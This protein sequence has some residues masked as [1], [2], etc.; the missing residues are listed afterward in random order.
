[1]AIQNPTTNYGW[2]L[3]TV[4]GSAD[5]WGTILNTLLGDDATGIDAIVKA[6]SDVANA[7]LPKAGGAMTGALLLDTIGE[8]TAGSGVTID[9]LLIK[10]GAI[11]ASGVPSLD[12]AK[13]TSGTFNAARIPSLDAAKITTG[14]FDAARI[15]DLSGTYATVASLGAYLADT[16]GGADWDV[17]TPEARFISGSTNGPE[18]AVTYIGINLPHASADYGVQ[19][20]GRD[21]D[22]YARSKESG[23]WSAWVAFSMAGHTHAASAISAGTFGAGT[24]VFPSVLQVVSNLIV[25]GLGQWGSF[26]RAQIGAA[27]VT[28]NGNEL[29][30]KTGSG[31]SG[32]MER[33]RVF[34][35]GNVGI[36]YATDQGYKLAVN[37]TGLFSGAVTASSF[38]KSA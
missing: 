21:G 16:V 18:A 33:A 31:T 28:D 7:A 3:P 20:A 32:V 19:F 37:G 29:I 25:G 27:D 12:A 4:G 10:D 8:R 30:L 38:I 17:T 35:N 1:M 15:P 9:G 24:Y 26:G 34:V 36:G 5:A 22:Y 14:T 11:P 23:V 6:V 13:I 2:T